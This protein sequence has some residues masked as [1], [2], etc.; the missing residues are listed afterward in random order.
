[1]TEET[2]TETVKV[3]TTDAK[4]GVVEG[5][6]KTEAPPKPDK[7]AGYYPVNFD[8]LGLTPE[9][10]AQ[11]EPRVRYLYGNLK[12]GE[13]ERNELRRWND[14]LQKAIDERITPLE[15]EREVTREV[16]LT[17]AIKQA[18]QLGDVETEAKLMK[19]LVQPKVE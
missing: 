15:K 4:V 19:E 5:E 2:K 6:T 17:E 1:M 8:E 16:Q 13:K 7:P 9:Q 11:I 3:E 10:R 18:R 14:D 12:A